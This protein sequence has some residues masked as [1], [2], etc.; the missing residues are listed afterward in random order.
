MSGDTE[1]RGGEI[2]A[3]V[4]KGKEVETDEVPALLLDLEGIGGGSGEDAGSLVETG[5]VERRHRARGG[6]G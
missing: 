6:V 4:H 5:A 3:L 2:I 1:A